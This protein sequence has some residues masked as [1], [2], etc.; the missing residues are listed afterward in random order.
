MR[1]T[2]PFSVGKAFRLPLAGILLLA[3]PMAWANTPLQVTTTADSFDGLCDSHCS[4]RDAVRT[5]NLQAGADFIMLAPGDYMLSLPPAPDEQGV[6]HDED[7]NRN[8]DLDVRDALTIRGYGERSRILGGG[9][10]RLLE[11]LA[12]ATLDLLRLSL[13]GGNTA[14]NG[15]AVENHGDLLLHEVRVRNNRAVTAPGPLPASEGYRHGQGGG[16]ANYG[17]LDV[18]HSIFEGNHAEVVYWDDNLGR[19]GAIF[20]QGQLLVRD[21]EFRDNRVSD[22]GDRGA[23]G[24]LY[25]AGTASVARSL[26]V[27]NSGDE[28]GLGGAIANEGEGMLVLSN[29]TIS[30]NTSGG[31]SNGYPS[32]TPPAVLPVMRLVHVSVVGNQGYGLMNRGEVLRRNSLIVANRDPVAGQVVNCRN[33]GQ[34]RYR[35]IGL[36]LETDDGSCRADLYVDPALTGVQLLHPLADNGGPTQTHA[37]R[38]SGLALDASIGSCSGHDQRA[39][40]RPLDGDGDG[41]AQCDLGAYEGHLP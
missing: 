35:A 27:D 26:F 20:N 11:V 4:L 10:D 15:G 9:S 5:A 3:G 31:L 33:L 24:G 2:T 36:L 18:H 39:V 8:G 22:Q 19:G 14:D 13:E 25:N 28:L 30:S 7:D 6:P 32:S 12:G 38:S 37:L 34:S 16:I 21:S 40:A 29:S 23:G 17:Q 1:R 41:V